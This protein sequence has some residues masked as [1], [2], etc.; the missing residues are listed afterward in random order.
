[1]IALS[2]MQGDGVSLVKGTMIGFLLGLTDLRA[3]RFSLEFPWKDMVSGST[4]CDIGSGLG[5]I[6]LE[7]AKTHSHLKLTLQDQP[8]ILEQARGVSHLCRFI[9]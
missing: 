1:M 3:P 7:L 6:S 8:H 5:A 9:C 2:E 4:I